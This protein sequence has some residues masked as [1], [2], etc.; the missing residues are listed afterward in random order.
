MSVRCSILYISSSG[1]E[2]ALNAKATEVAIF[3]SASEGFSMKNINCSIQVCETSILPRSS[4]SNLFY[5]FLLHKQ[6]SLD[7]FK[8]IMEAA[9]KSNVRVRGY[10]G[11]VGMGCSYDVL[12]TGVC[13]EFFVVLMMFS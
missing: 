4:I 7:R 5:L 13:C 2:S 1:F 6:E 9:Q 11:D 3:A 12:V 10:A 8:P